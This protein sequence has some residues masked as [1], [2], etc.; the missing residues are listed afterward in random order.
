[1]TYPQLNLVMLAVAA[2]AAV[3][4]LL[5]RRIRARR[6]SEPPQHAPGS[7]ALPSSGPRITRVLSAFAIALAGLVLLTAVFD[8]VMISAGLFSYADQGRTGWQIGRAPIEDF[9][10]PLAALLLLPAL[11]VFVRDHERTARTVLLSSRPLS[12]INT[13]FP[14]AAAFALGV[15]GGDPQLS[16]V[17][18]A[19][20]WSTLGLV[21]GTL[22]FLVP[23][24]LL[25]YGIN[26]VFDYESDLRN[27]RKGGAEG[28]LLEPRLH[29][30][31]VLSGVISAAPFVSLMLVAAW[32]LGTMVAGAITLAVS[33][34]LVVAYS[35]PGLRFKERPVVDSITSSLHFVTPAVCGL[36]FAGVELTWPL[37]ALL[38]A[39][40][41][42]GM[43]SHA[44]GAVQDVIPDREGGISSIATVLGAG[45]TV[46]LAIWLWS[47]AGVLTL[48]TSWPGPLG[49]L[50]VVPYIVAVWPFRSISDERSA[51]AN[52]GWRRFL[53][54]NYACGFCVTMLL[55]WWASL[56]L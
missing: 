1:M 36:A 13:A 45:R 51:Q 15:G 5:A 52:V 21:A 47:A 26:D 35:V 9:A 7:G 41:L 32:H 23:Y 34:F 53:A 22:F 31:V 50:L 24:N 46:R 27:A 2:G 19:G 42:W 16:A 39:F 4:C 18:A 30:T 28:A 38:V 56:N 6:A 10:Y 14:F 12:W 29:R 43:A 17:S 8:N 40:G 20:S 25:M 44:F 33:L 54:I 48:F 11:W 37:I 55:I 49:A 3:L